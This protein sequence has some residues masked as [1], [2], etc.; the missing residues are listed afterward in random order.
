LHADHGGRVS[1]LMRRPVVYVHEDFSL[2]QVLQAF[3]KT[4]NHLFIVVNEFEEF[5]GII[6]IEDVIDQIIGR[7]LADEFDNYTDL[8]AVAAA[9]AKAEHFKHKK[10]SSEPTE[11]IE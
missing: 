10:D 5:V 6:T 4:Y 7:P 2:G 9:S 8:R 1:T 3:L 11:V